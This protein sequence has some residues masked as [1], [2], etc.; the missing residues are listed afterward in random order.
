MRAPSAEYVSSAILARTMGESVHPIS[1]KT[2]HAIIANGSVNAFDGIT[3]PE[4]PGIL[5][6]Q[7]RQYGVPYVSGGNP[8]DGHSYDDS[9][10]IPIIN[11]M[12]RYLIDLVKAC[13]LPLRPIVTCTNVAWMC[14]DQ[15]PLVEYNLWHKK[16]GYAAESLWLSYFF[17]WC[18]NDG[19]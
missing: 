7:L 1:A 12:R 9:N 13:I 8:F 4:E 11:V 18:S 2:L 15:E 10:Y 5:S 6:R 17:R 3:L 19:S 14:F 16:T